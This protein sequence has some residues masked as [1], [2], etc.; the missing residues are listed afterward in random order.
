[1]SAQKLVSWTARFGRWLPKHP[2]PMKTT[3]RHCFLVNFAMDAKTLR[4]VLPKGLEPD[5]HD[6]SGKAFVSV[7]LADL[8]AMRPGFI[9]RA[10]GSDFTQVVYRAIVRAPTGERGVYFLR[11]DADDSLSGI[12]MAAA[13]NLLSNFRFHLGRASWAGLE[14]LQDWSALEAATSAEAATAPSSSLSS[15]VVSFAMEPHSDGKAMGSGIVRAN[16]DMASANAAMPASSVF[17]GQPLA[18]AKAY[19]VELYAAFAAWSAHWAAVRIDRTRWDVVAVEHLEHRCYNFM[20]GSEGGLFAPGECTLD[21]VFFVRDLDYHWHVAEKYPWLSEAGAEAEVQAAKTTKPPL[22]TMFY[23]GSCPMCAKEVGLYVRQAA[24][25]GAALAFFDVSNDD[26]DGSMGGL[27]PTHFNV[28]REEALAELHV[29]THSY[30]RGGSGGSSDA[31]IT[32][33]AKIV[34]TLH[35]G[36]AAFVEVWRLLPYWR[37]LAT[38]VESVPLVLPAAEVIYQLFAAKRVAVGG[39]LFGDARAPAAPV[40]TEPL[41]R[42]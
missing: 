5:V 6:A 41:V 26:A 1:M 37:H 24:E 10:L 9:P 4:R 34:N 7:V 11:S 18:P 20:D 36:A 39:A 38:F 27:G 17:A 21:S 23:D 40:V 35:V 2:L 42:S 33:D 22:A 30:N 31:V 16:F 12:A 3:F 14:Y 15:R 28:T 32:A 8:E 19:F 29:V 13:G 25:S